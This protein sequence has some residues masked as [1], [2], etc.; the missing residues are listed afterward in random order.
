MQLPRFEGL[1]ARR[2]GRLLAVY[3]VVGLLAGI[4]AVGFVLAVGYGTD[5]LDRVRTEGSPW[6]VVLLPVAGGL[7]SGLLCAWLAPETMGAG[8]NHV[9]E[10]YHHHDGEIRARVP[11]VKTVAA[12]ITLSSG[13]SGGVEGPVAQITAG[14][15]A[16][17]A[18][19]MGLPPRDRR[20]M[21]MAGFAAGIGAVFHAPMAAALFA[22]E[23][24]Y[25]E[26][27]MEHEVL[28]PAIIA[29]TVAYGTFGATLGWEQTLVLSSAQFGHAVELL[30]YLV[31]A[32]VVGI[33]AIGF[34]ELYRLV[35]RKIGHNAA[36]PLWL[37][38]A[39]GGVFIGL[40]GLVAPAALG[41]G[42]G[43]VET[44]LVGNPTILLLLGLALAKGV[45]TAFT[46][47][48]GAAAGLF[49]PSL[50]I[51]GALGGAV[52]L[53][54]DALVP[55]LGVH[56]AAFVVVGMAGFFAAVAN[57]PLSTVI[58]V[59]EIVGSYRLLVPALWVCTIAWL[60]TRTR[61]IYH[62]QA[63]SRLDAPAQLADM[64][65]AVLDRITVRQAMA[66][67]A[68]EPQTVP[69]NM[70][71]R[72]LLR[73]FAETRQ[74][75]FPLMDSAGRLTGVVDG[76]QLR[77]TLGERGAEDYLIAKDFQAP[78][79]T[80]RPDATLYVAI[81]QMMATGYDELV[82]VTEEDE[83]AGFISRREI[84]TAYYARMLAR[85]PGM[86]DEAKP[87]EK[88]WSL[89][90]A[91]ERGGIV[92]GVEASTVEATI[93]AIMAQA[94]LPAACERED[95]LRRLL[96][97]EA[98]GST[99]VGNGVALPHAHEENLPGIDKPRVI[100]AQ[101]KSPMDW[102]AYDGRPVDTVCILFCDSA[103]THLKLLSQLA[104]GLM[105]PTVRRLL[106]QRAAQPK[107]LR[108]IEATLVS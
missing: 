60:L 18:E 23:V 22:S 69:E 28:V 21:L 74:A 84:V 31:L 80:V 89:L 53:A 38:P 29:A 92:Q 88:E 105:D 10:A 75:V 85:T 71:L 97:R 7:L 42:Y 63:T 59:A 62:E 9:I 65:G 32:L 77:R 76:R 45:A 95:L 13:G 33:S 93:R 6:L 81:S 57:A 47:G 68:P 103:E 48:S 34:V 30:P 2:V 54:T 12:T 24:L 11:A 37:R 19:R 17:V 58:M 79:P 4:V 98:L 78:T 87:A 106:R 3:C 108:A 27:D 90:G 50:V 46:A 82:V 5:L 72:E 101:L 61:H 56:Q 8:I 107:L 15:G 102:D 1:E 39:V 20:V 96:E 64:M 83:L 44:A 100:V 52:G 55:D 43:I 16:I 66:S 49:A 25:R 26:M 14:I 70:P 51:G 35:D 41:S 94:D 40:V 104:R 86:A 73:L 36:I 99:G 67:D 91:I